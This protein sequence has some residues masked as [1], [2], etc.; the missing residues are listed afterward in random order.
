L[1]EAPQKKMWGGRFERDPEAGFWEFQRSFGFDRRLL[2]QELAVDRAW[3]RA[4]LA[5]QAI[6]P[7]E[8]A[9]IHAALDAIEKRAHD[10]PAWVASSNAEDVHHFVEMH[11][12][13]LAGE[14]GGKLHTGRSRNELVVTEFRLWIRE[15]AGE[16]RAGLAQLIRALLAHAA[17]HPALPMPGNTHLQHAQPILLAHWL[18][19]H[20]EGYFHDADRAAFAA[21]TANA[22][23]MGTGA[24]AGC[25]VP[26]DR[27]AIARELGF[28]R[29][30]RN[31]LDTV[32]RRDFPLDYLYALSVTAL[33]LSRLAEDVTWF[34]TPEFAF[35]TL[36]DE[37]STGSSLMPQK[38]NPD[39]WELIRGK[40]GRVIA[41]LNGLMVTVK[42]LPTG[43]QRDLQEDKEPVFNAHDEVL[44][45]LRVAAGAIAATKFNAAR[46]R[47]MAADPGL[48]ATEVADY[49]V[50]RDVPFRE[51][52]EI[53]GRVIRDAESTGHTLRTL[54]LEQWKKHSPEFE[55][56][57]A[58][59]LTVE[60][61]IARKKSSG[62]TAPEMVAAALADAQA[63]LA[64]LEAR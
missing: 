32:S 13:E 64:A 48:V 62:G 41:A 38:K 31:S 33:H 53:T 43:Y 18:L 49:L 63:R 25:T 20:A 60:S 34:A 54:P 6:T 59:W 35:V 30:T 19:A 37:Y 15:A 8:L 52:H 47:E 4:L 55:A 11:V 45:M 22:C 26:V 14:A 57:L 2:P 51:A 56:D 3:T 28:A 39:A 24:L 12:R 5:A 23:P 27:M 1:S 42:G 17:Q 46:L 16:L 29:I 61:A 7:Q 44:A 58:Q 10:E 36:P 21:N 50:A 9:Q 40:C